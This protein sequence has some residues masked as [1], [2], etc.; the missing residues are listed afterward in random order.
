M[1]RND[2]RRLE[3]VAG[4]RVETV[5]WGLR[6]QTDTVFHRKGH[7]EPRDS[8]EFAVACRDRPFSGWRGDE[9]VVA[10]AVVTY[11]TEWTVVPG[12]EGSR[13]MSC[14]HPGAPQGRTG[15]SIMRDDPDCPVRMEGPDYQRPHAWRE[16]DMTAGEDGLLRYT[17]PVCG[18]VW[19]CRAAAPAPQGS[20]F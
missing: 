12:Y 7:V 16:R 18:T 20:L 11:T 4:R 13:H 19:Q 15:P 10:R 6:T 3:E 1:R 17:C 2:R 8:I 14:D 9:Q 5:E